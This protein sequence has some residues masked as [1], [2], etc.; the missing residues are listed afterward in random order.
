MRHRIQA[1]SYCFDVFRSSY[2]LH[3]EISK[4]VVSQI[5]GKPVYL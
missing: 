2:A 4:A 3:I 1:F 5:R